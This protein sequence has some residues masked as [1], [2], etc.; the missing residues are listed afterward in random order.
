[1]THWLFKH[2]RLIYVFIITFCFA[3]LILAG[4][5][6]LQWQKQETCE[7]IT[8]VWVDIGHLIF[9]KNDANIDLGYNFN[10]VNI[11]F[12]SNLLD[13]ILYEWRWIEKHDLLP[14]A[15]TTKY[16]YLDIKRQDSAIPQN[17]KSYSVPMMLIIRAEE[18]VFHN[19][20]NTLDYSK[21]I[22]SVDID[23]RA[24]YFARN[25]SLLWE[26]YT[27]EIVLSNYVIDSQNG[28]E[29]NQQR[30]KGELF[31]AVNNTKPLITPNLALGVDRSDNVFFSYGILQYE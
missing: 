31:E 28:T 16:L 14:I 9:Q 18:T 29:K 3:L 2:K 21:K 20:P 12:R 7:G 13:G 6:V 19:N 15:P 26:G 8:D 5:L 1:M 30:I 17:G 10:L 4:S 22:S 24:V 23:G 25:D 27:S 11:Y